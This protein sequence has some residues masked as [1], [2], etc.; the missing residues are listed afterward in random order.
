MLERSRLA[1]LIIALGMALFAITSYSLLSHSLLYVYDHPTVQVMTDFRQQS[2]A[3]LL[4]LGHALSLLGNVGLA[5]ISLVLA[6]FW[7]VKK[8][9]RPI[10]LLI[11]LPGLGGLLFLG[12]A[13]LFGRQRPSLPGLLSQIPLPSYPSGHVI[14]VVTFVTLLLYL[15]LPRVGSASWRV[16]IWTCAIL[17]VLVEGL[18]RLYLGAHYLTDVLAAYGLGIAW[19]VFGLLVVDWYWFR[20]RKRAKSKHV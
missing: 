12:L 13:Y 19:A 16:V 18:D 15:Y 7:L 9:Y 14:G 1:W 5:G 20:R 2:P 4:T 6:I 11:A 17:L 10:I 3:W 8:R